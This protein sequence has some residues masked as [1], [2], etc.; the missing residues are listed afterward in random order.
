MLFSGD[1]NSNMSLCQFGSNSARYPIL[2][3]VIFKLKNG[4]LYAN[5]E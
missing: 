3:P 5:D 4:T 1:N 2:L